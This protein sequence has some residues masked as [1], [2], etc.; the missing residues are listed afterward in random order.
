MPVCSARNRIHSGSTATSSAAKSSA[1][2]TGRLPNGAAESVA[3]QELGVLRLVFSAG[4]DAFHLADQKRVERLGVVCRGQGGSGGGGANGLLPSGQRSLGGRMEAAVH[5]DH[6]VSAGVHI[7]Q[8][9]P[10][11]AVR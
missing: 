5:S 2:P 6:L 11:R 9:P 10:A 1:G 4:P 7:P 8:V 3:A